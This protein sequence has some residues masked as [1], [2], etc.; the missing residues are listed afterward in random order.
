MLNNSNPTQPNKQDTPTRRQFLTTLATIPLIAA[1][2]LSPI[3]GIEYAPTIPPPYGPAERTAIIDKWI[4]RLDETLI[5]LEKYYSFLID[6][7]GLAPGQ[8][9]GVQLVN[10]ENEVHRIC[11]HMVGCI[12]CDCEN[13]IISAATGRGSGPVCVEAEL[14]SD[15][16]TFDRDF[17]QREVDAVSEDHPHERARLQAL[18]NAKYRGAL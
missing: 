5:T 12:D 11:D 15:S 10:L 18:L 2:P 8:V 4:G 13:S 17:W 6:A 1:V 14:T 16:H 9:D 7:R 3:G